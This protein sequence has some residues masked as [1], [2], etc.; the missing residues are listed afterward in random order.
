MSLTVDLDRFK[1]Q[2]LNDSKDHNS[3]PTF[4][5]NVPLIE[6]HN[7]TEVD[8]RNTPLMPS[9]RASQSKSINCLKDLA[10]EML[11]SRVKKADS[12]VSRREQIQ[13]DYKDSAKSITRKEIAKE[14]I[15]RNELNKIENKLEDTLDK[16]KRI[17]KQIILANADE[18]DVEPSEYVSVHKRTMRSKAGDADYEYKL[19]LNSH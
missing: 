8:R 1:G 2:G 4:H 9:R 13:K 14:S 16:D 19:K 3:D 17:Y 15:F 11:Y 12:V 18:H 7:V 6:N 10:N 5:H